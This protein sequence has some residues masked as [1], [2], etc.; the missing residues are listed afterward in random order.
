VPR[1]ALGVADEYG[2]P[3]ALHGDSM[4][5]TGYLDD[6]IDGRRVHT[7]HTEGIGGGHA[8]GLIKIAGLPNVLPSTISATIP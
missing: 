8:P 6:T 5:E 2:V 3:V 1:C 4:R 7:Y